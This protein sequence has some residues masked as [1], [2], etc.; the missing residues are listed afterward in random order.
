MRSLFVRVLACP[1]R[2]SGREK[3]RERKRKKKWSL[4]TSVALADLLFS[5]WLAFHLLSLTASLLIVASFFVFLV[6]ERESSRPLVSL[7]L[8]LSS[9]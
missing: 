7:S 8:S 4:T 6:R 2:F 1:A 3:K 5:L 9:S